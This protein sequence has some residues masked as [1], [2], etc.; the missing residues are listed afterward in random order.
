MGKNIVNEIE[1]GLYEMGGLRKLLLILE[2][3]HDLRMLIIRNNGK[4]KC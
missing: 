3:L 4:F 2:T 1:A